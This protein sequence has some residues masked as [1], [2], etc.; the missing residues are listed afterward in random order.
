MGF[1]MHGLLLNLGLGFKGVLKLVALNADI[2]LLVYTISII[3]MKFVLQ[4]CLQFYQTRSVS[5]A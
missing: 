3:L 2:N 1:M 5:Y 4:A